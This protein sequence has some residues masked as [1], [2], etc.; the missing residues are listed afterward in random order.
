MNKAITSHITASGYDRLACDI[1]VV[2]LGFGAFHRA[3][4]AVFLDD[5]MAQTGDLR[6]GIAAVNL[7]AA[8]ADSFGEHDA[9]GAGYLLKSV[10][11]SGDVNLSRIR[12][13]IAF[14]DWSRDRGASEALL[15]RASVKL[16]TITVTESG[17]YTDPNGVLDIADP[18]IAAEVA[19]G[20]G[21]SVYAYL[22][23]ALTRRMTTINAPIT[24]SCCDN[25]R[26]NG[27]MLQRNFGAYLA[28]IGLD[29]LKVWVTENVTF[30]N[31]MVDRITP[32]ATPELAFEFAA[33]TGETARHPVLAEAF[34]QWV[35]EDN[36][37]TDM[38]DL[39]RVGVT[40]TKDVDPFEVTKI[41]VLNGGHTCLA[42]LAALRGVETFDQAMQVPDLFD[43]FW[44]YETTEVLPALTLALPFSKEAYLDSIAARFKNPAIADTVARICADG[45]A[46]FP[47]FMRPTLEGCLRQ[48]IMPT[49]GIVSIASWHVF[50]R[51]VQAGKAPLDYAEPSWPLLEAM[52][53]SDA[54]VL[55]QQLWGDLPTT[56]PEFADALRTAIKEMEQSWPL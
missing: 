44:T 47:I 17:Y 39:A 16:V 30:P 7:R 31:S 28:A 25:I 4:Q 8:E 29:D 12:S 43:H 27:R 6:W 40:I 13:H 15:A 23:A 55:S 32:R 51:H 21:T 9:A 38:P 41:R 2:H 45:F 33:M 11:P 1:G 35:L 24:I 22:A 18:L 53:G 19:G 49:R 34:V 42:Y 20:E 56:Y 10:A 46:K 36:F 52:L 26:S 48:G 14:S 54:F 5:Y 50:A 3:H 37:A